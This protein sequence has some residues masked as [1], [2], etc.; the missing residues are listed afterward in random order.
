M[1]GIGTPLW[2]VRTAGLG[3]FGTFSA[4]EAFRVCGVG[5]RGRKLNL[6]G[7]VWEEAWQARDSKQTEK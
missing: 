4:P 6:L 1:R 5:G 2:N 7:H 3:L